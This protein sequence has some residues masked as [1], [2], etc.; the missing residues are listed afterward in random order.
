MAYYCRSKTKPTTE[1][2]QWLDRQMI[3]VNVSTRDVADMLHCGAITVSYHRSGKRR[4]TF[5][6]VVAYCW[7][8][9]CDDDPETVWQMVDIL[10]EE[11]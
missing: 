3:L 7:A 8:F 1:F 2:G 6:D 5:S 9:S 4:P 10:I 11:E